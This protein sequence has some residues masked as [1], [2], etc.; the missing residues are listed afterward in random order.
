[1]SKDSV[2]NG[3]TGCWIIYVDMTK[4]LMEMGGVRN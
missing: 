2:Q 4:H 1:M 3:S